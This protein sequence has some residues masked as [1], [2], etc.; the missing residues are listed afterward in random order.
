MEPIINREFRDIYHNFVY[1]DCT[2]EKD[3]LR[4]DLGFSEEATGFIGYGIAE[5]M[6]GLSFLILGEGILKDDNIISNVREENDFARINYEEVKFFNSVLKD[7]LN[8]DE[9]RYEEKIKSATL[10]LEE[11]HEARRVF[12]EMKELD[13]SRDFGLPDYLS[14]VFYG[15]DHFPEL[16]FVRAHSFGDNNIMFG[17]VARAPRQNFG[18][19]EGDIV[20]FKAFQSDKNISLY[21]VDKDGEILK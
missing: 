17:E 14:I 2:D 12:R 11:K 16:S 9:S 4:K 18:I 8:L 6:T 15:G 10:N 7:K 1:V 21:L 5:P 3:K 13:D 20:P 19:K